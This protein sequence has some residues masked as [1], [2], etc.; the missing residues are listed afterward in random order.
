[1]YDKLLYLYANYTID[2]SPLP[3]VDAD[4]GAVSDIL[5]VVFTIIGA[6]SLLFFVAG[7]FRYITSQGDPSE[8]SKAKNTLIYSL[9]GLL[10]SIFAVAIVTFVL[11]RLG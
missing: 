5:A 4:Q 2:S 10:V 1:M 8:I 11:G 9:V 3:D 7:G 6:L